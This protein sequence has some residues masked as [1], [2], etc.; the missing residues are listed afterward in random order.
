MGGMSLDP[1]LKDSASGLWLDTHYAPMGNVLLPRAE[2][3][4]V[5]DEVTDE[6]V[7]MTRCDRFTIVLPHGA[8]EEPEEE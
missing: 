7:I 3:D 5:A 2:A 8:H 6:V 4:A 1:Y